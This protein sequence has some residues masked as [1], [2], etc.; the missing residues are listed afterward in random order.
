MQEFYSAE[1]AMIY[2]VE[3]FILLIDF[4]KNC[5]SYANKYSVLKEILFY[6][7]SFVRF[8]DLKLTL[9]QQD[10]IAGAV[11]SAIKE[12]QLLQRT[13]NWKI[14]IDTLAENLRSTKTNAMRRLMLQQFGE[15]DEMAKCS[16]WI[17]LRFALK[18]SLV[19]ACYQAI[20]HLSKDLIHLAAQQ[21]DDLQYLAKIGHYKFVLGK[22]I[23]IY[24][25]YIIQLPDENSIPSRYKLKLIEQ[26]L[27]SAVFPENEIVIDKLHQLIKNY[28]EI[29]ALN[30]DDLFQPLHVL[31]VRAKLTITM[32]N[33]PRTLAM[34]AEK[35]IVALIKL[36]KQ[37]THKM[38]ARRGMFL[39]VKL[40]CELVLNEN[41]LSKNF[42]GL[43]RN[44]IEQIKS[45]SL[46]F[47]THYSNA[48]KAK[49]KPLAAWYLAF[50]NY[51]VNSKNHNGM[52]VNTMLL[53]L[54][55]DNKVKG[56]IQ[57]AMKR[58]FFYSSRQIE[59]VM[60]KSERSDSQIQMY[61][62]G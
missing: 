23:L 32:A 37:Q 36:A 47:V 41:T 21:L 40:Y 29:E 16:D 17:N 10:E 54:S 43:D 39:S 25:D 48:S 51:I 6:Y 8:N 57:Y 11:F 59:E 14:V 28:N 4:L 56:D 49:Y 44:V 33:E 62:R 35:Y 5:D 34:L 61:Q 3:V 24:L 22:Y 58:S 1:Y 52:T 55:E 30:N 26:C 60:A 9:E 2:H 7:S 50:M 18:K 27:R 31:S 13:V 38:H 12:S 53:L 42:Y 19:E 46:K 15:L 20:N 45:H